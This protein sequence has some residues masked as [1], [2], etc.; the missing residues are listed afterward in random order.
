[1]RVR[2]VK[3]NGWLGDRQPEEQG[4]GKSQA[5]CKTEVDK[6]YQELLSMTPE[7]KHTKQ[8]ALSLHLTCLHPIHTQSHTPLV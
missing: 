1:M 3:R 8:H 7:F 4:T 6:C 2:K 5:H